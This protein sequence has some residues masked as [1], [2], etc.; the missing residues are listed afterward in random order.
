M[1]FW[2]V[3]ELFKQI[4][5]FYLIRKM[6]FIDCLCLHMQSYCILLAHKVLTTSRN[7]I[8]IMLCTN[9]YAPK[10][11]NLFLIN[12]RRACAAMVTVVVLCVCLS[13]CLC[14]RFLHSAF[15]CF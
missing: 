7:V 8:T 13:V 6:Y 12:P 10:V 15:S 2:G 3:H 1:Q 11:A 9:L 14:I 4:T 5:T